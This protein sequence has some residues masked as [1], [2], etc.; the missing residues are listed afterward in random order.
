MGDDGHFSGPYSSYQLICVRRFIPSVRARVRARVKVRIRARVRVWVRGL[1]GCA[2]PL[3]PKEW[4]ECG[5]IHRFA[6]TDI[7]DRSKVGKEKI[8]C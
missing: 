5:L 3:T 2:Q 7:R 6:S 1:I 8:L 4:I